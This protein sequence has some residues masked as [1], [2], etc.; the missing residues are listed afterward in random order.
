MR[1]NVFGLMR[2]EPTRQQKVIAFAVQWLISAAA[3]WVAA[4]LVDGIFLDG[5]FTTFAVALF[6]GLLNVFVKPVLVLV[7]LPALVLTLGLFLIVINTA[8]LALIAWFCGKFDD[9]RF[10]I[11][12]FWDAVLGAIIISVV[13]F[14][15]TRFIDPTSVARGVSRR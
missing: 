5:W 9:L 8:L 10:A 14:L 11:D 15:V 6:L 4:E 3:V 1:L 7:A 2:R 13:T 12:G